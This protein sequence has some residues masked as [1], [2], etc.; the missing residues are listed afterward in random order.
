LYTR[1]GQSP[2][3][4]L[5]YHTDARTFHDIVTGRICPQDSFFS[6]RVR[7]SGDIEAALKLMVLFGQ[8]LAETAAAKPE[9]T[10]VF[11]STAA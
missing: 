5:T 11:D 3:A 8:L 4:A 2:D 7:I 6:E 10:E 1:K 9:G